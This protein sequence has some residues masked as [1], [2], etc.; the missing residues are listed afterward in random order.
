MRTFAGNVGAKAALVRAD[1]FDAF[2]NVLLGFFTKALE[3]GQLAV[4]AG[5]GQTIELFDAQCFADGDD[6]ARA[7]SGDPQH[8][9]QACRHRRAQLYIGYGSAGLGKFD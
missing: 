3:S 5:L 2:K 6:L 9:E 8:V 1:I 4:D 7:E